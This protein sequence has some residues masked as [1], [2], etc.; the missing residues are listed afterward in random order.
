[1]IATFIYS[2]VKLV[3]GVFAVIFGLVIG[4]LL[5]LVAL[6]TGVCYQSKRCFKGLWKK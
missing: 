5:F 6:P 3:L 2:I 1:M 4:F